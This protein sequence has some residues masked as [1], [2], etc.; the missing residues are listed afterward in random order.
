ME[1]CRFQRQCSVKQR[2]YHENILFSFFF[3]DT[4]FVLR[5]AT[6]FYEK[7]L[8]SGCFFN[9]HS[10]TNCLLLRVIAG[11]QKLGW[12][13]L[14]CLGSVKVALKSTLF[15]LSSPAQIL[16]LTSCFPF[17]FDLSLCISVILPL[18]LI[19]ITLVIP[20]Q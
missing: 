7:E 8:L 17:L 16:V 13:S 20:C 4:F 3:F 10:Y 19:C 18:L 12:T 9:F 14:S 11:L 2:H 1:I 15:P 6:V 5:T